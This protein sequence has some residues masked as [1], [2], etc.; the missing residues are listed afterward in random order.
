MIKASTTFTI[1]IG[2]ALL[3]TT[4]V[5]A[6]QKQAMSAKV[7]PDKNFFDELNKREGTFAKYLFLASPAVRDD[8]SLRE[9]AAQMLATDLS[10]LGRPNDALRA[11]PM[12][13]DDRPR[14]DD[15]LSVPTISAFNAMPAVDWITNEASNYRMIMVNEAHHVPQTRVLTFSLLRTLCDKGFDVLAVETLVNNGYEPLA[16]GYPNRGTGMYSQEPVFAELLR[17]AKRLGYK[18][19][20]YETNAA[21]SEE[22]QQQRETGQAQAIADFLASN[23]NARILVHAG[24]GHINERQK[25][26]PDSARP[27]AMELARLT[28]LPMLTVDQTSTRSYELNDIKTIGRQLSTRFQVTEPSVLIDRKNGTP[29]S[30]KPGANDVSV[31]LPTPSASPIRPDWLTLGG[32]RQAMMV[33]MTPCIDHLPCLAEARYTNEGDDAIPADQFVLLSKDETSAP[34]YLAPGRYR[35]RLVGNEGRALTEREL[36]V[37]VATSGTPQSTAIP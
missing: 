1:A 34:L 12:R 35:L 8:P 9:L 36:S 22:T 21:R 24:Y 5:A 13:K 23:P 4:A 7:D 16:K 10:F 19:L 32:I 2:L 26:S 30:N 27:M 31:L 3:A 25:D 15:E 17:E 14:P 28:D 29:W 6:D 37:A 20:P 18:L 11:F 33:D